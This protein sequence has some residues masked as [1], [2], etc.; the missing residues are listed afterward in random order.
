MRISTFQPFFTR[1]ALGL[2]FAAS[3][4]FGGVPDVAVTSSGTDSTL[5]GVIASLGVVAGVALGVVY[6]NMSSARDV[7]TKRAE[8]ADAELRAVLT[9]TDE[10]IVILDGNGTIRGANPATE[11]IFGKSSDELIGDELGNLIAHPMNLGE[12]SKQGP[13]LFTS[14]KAGAGI[15]ERLEIV[16]SEVHLSRGNT[17]LAIVRNSKTGESVDFAPAPAPS[18][19]DLTAPVGRFAHDFNNILTSITG[20]LSLILMTSSPDPVTMERITGAKRAALKAQ[21]LNRKLLALAKGEDEEPSP[22]TIVQMPQTMPAAKEPTAPK[23]NR[24]VLILDD[25]M[26]ICSLVT[27]VLGPMGYDVTE[28]Y[29][30]TQAIAA[31]EEAKKAGKPYDLVISDL[32]LP[33][34]VSGR[35]VVQRMQEMIPGLKAIVSSGHDADP[36]MSD[37]RKHGFC[38]A[39]PK[40]YDVSKLGCVVS[41]ALDEEST[42]KTA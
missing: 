7:L 19:P 16:L 41:K 37:C 40:P 42:R 33:G 31:C 13:A 14:T 25:E 21:E 10:A 24:R 36:V 18:F 6:R 29:D 4:A 8:A 9:M 11:E 22:S 35:D 39:I 26:E 27:L 2:G 34:G 1:V 3:S 32:S 38:A 23:R 17:Y 30:A 5:L 20:N 12:L 28:A 15:G